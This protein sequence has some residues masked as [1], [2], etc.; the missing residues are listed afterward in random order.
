MLNILFIGHIPPGD[1]DCLKVWS[2]HF[3]K[4]VDRYEETIVAQFYGHRHTDEFEVF[5]DAET[6]SECLSSVSSIKKRFYNL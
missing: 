2:E 3:Y 5:Y 1:S 6:Y 4:I